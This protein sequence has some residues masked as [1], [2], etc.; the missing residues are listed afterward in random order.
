MGNRSLKPIR[1][2]RL[3]ETI[4]ARLEDMILAGDYRPGEALPTENEMAAQ[5]EV[6]RTVVRD[7]IRVLA[8]KGLVEI[9]H[10]VGTFITSSGRERLA[11]ALA[12][13]LRRG[14]YTPAELYTVRCGLELTVVE[15]A[16][17]MV[18]PAQIGTM[19]EILARY[20]AQL[21]DPDRPRLPD[22][23]MAFHQTMVRAT[24]NRVL[25]DLLDPIT[26]FR[27]PEHAGTAHMELPDN[28]A[29]IRAH[30]KI[31]DA[32]EARDVGAARAAMLDHLSV[33]QERA[34][35]ATEELARPDDSASVF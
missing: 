32:I 8:T 26:V 29:Y 35:R 31:I 4:A 14:D 30:E 27:I 9:R 7:A 28:D 33:L 1:R 34:R 5:L 6:S 15:E 25:I 17:K 13:S 16:I 12:L 19:R 3:H 2:Q 10:G 21:R 18:T 23:H 24:N 20:H 22:E 11:E